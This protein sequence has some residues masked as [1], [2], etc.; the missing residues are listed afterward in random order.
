MELV[1]RRGFS[2][3]EGA[4]FAA[5]GE[6]AQLSNSDAEEHDMADGD[7]LLQCLSPLLGS[8]RLLGLYFTKSS[9]RVVHDASRSTPAVTTD[10]EVSRDA[11]KWTGGRIYAVVMMVANWLNFGRMMTAFE[12]GDSFGVLLL[13]KLAA[14]SSAMFSA[15]LQTACFVACQT[16]NLDRVF[17]D[18]KLPQ[19]DLARYR[20]LAVI[21]TTVCWLFLLVD[22][23][24]LLVNALT[25]GEKSSSS[26]APFGVHVSVS[27][28][29]LFVINMM[30]V[31][32][33]IL[34]DFVWFFS[35]SVNRIHYSTVVRLRR[36]TGKNYVSY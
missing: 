5:I 28:E 32:A 9:R 8:M 20:R 30:M 31:V 2:V 14:I 7:A 1:D 18:A 12:K 26:I 6:D 4:S 22:I 35:H 29:A 33:F 25:V 34:T 10:P 3:W 36:L 23:L 16:G 21:H 24:G 15:G 19:S 27:G 11:K 17:R 13:M